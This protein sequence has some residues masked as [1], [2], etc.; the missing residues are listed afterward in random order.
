MT[1]LRSRAEALKLH[2][3]IAHWSDIKAEPWLDPLLGWEEQERSRR[4][5]E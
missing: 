1:D 2:G 4:G 3:L 5:L